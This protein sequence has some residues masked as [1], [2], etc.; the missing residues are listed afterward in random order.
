MLLEE[1]MQN[2][3]KRHEVQAQ[4]VWAAVDAWA[5][6][7]ALTLN[8]PEVAHRSLAVSAIKTQDALASRLRGWCADTAG[9]TLGVGFS[10]SRTE[11]QTDSAFRIGHMGHQSPHMLLGALG[12]IEAGLVAL[13]VPDVQ[14]GVSA[15]IRVIAAHKA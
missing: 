12:S 11:E 2:V 4:A 10:L 8:V 7:G 5:L 3:W 15:A 13:G 9:V 1:G 6:S 14:G